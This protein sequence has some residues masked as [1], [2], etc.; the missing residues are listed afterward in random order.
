MDK[1]Y[2]C[3]TSNLIPSLRLLRFANY[4]DIEYVPDTDA[5]KITDEITQLKPEAE[6]Q[7]TQRRWL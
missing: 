3:C 7:S 5:H 2:F 1:N 6:H 4:H